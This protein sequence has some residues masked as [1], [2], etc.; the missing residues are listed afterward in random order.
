[1]AIHLER[2]PFDADVHDPDEVRDALMAHVHAEVR[3]AGEPRARVYLIGDGHVDTLDL[4]ALIAAEPSAHVGATVKAARERVGVEQ[5]WL[6]ALLDAEDLGGTHHRFAVLGALDGAIAWWVL[7]YQTD[8]QSGV[9]LPGSWSPAEPRMIERADI[10]GRVLAVPDGAQ[11]AEVLAARRPPLDLRAA[12]FELPESM[13]IPADARGQADLG[14]KVAVADLLSGAIAGTAIVKLSGRHGELWVLGESHQ[15]PDDLL[16]A[17]AGREPVADGLA[18]C[19]LAL[20]EGSDP[21]QKGV[22]IVAERGS[23]R[24]ERWL[25]LAFSDGPSGKPVVH[26]AV[27]RIVAIDDD[28]GWIGVPPLVPIELSPLGGEA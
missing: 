25:L 12:F 26:R 18:I 23:E 17:I 6:V 11:P 1:M 19:L 24:V 4:E 5:S 10:V 28:E 27:E 15:D 16:R 3:L 21:P 9:G 8:A 20:F 7:P 22:Q 13:P 14:V 2:R